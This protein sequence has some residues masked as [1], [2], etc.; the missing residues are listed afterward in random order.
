[1]PLARKRTSATTSGLRWSTLTSTMEVCGILGAFCNRRCRS[2]AE[3]CWARTTSFSKS[4]SMSEST[5]AFGA[6]SAD[7]ICLTSVEIGALNDT[8]CA[9]KWRLKLLQFLFPLVSWGSNSL[10]THSSSVID[11]SGTVSSRRWKR[12][13]RLAVGS[14]YR[15]VTS[16]NP[17][18]S[19]VGY[20][21]SFWMI[22]T[23]SFGC[24]RSY[25][26]R[27]FSLSP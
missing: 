16:Y 21:F 15:P 1:M 8:P 24:T 14:W 19:N 17:H 9:Q 10:S 5:T 11:L 2:S 20:S 22:K 26:H 12:K 7:K 25:F 6:S 27:C 23:L 4:L 18:S 13:G 3:R